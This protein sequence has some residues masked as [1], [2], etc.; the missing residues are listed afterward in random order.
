LEI[1]KSSTD[2]N[3]P[4][5]EGLFYLIT[6]WRSLEHVSHPNEA[7]QQFSTLLKEIGY[8]I[9]AV[10]NFNSFN[11]IFFKDNWFHLDAPRHL[12]IYTPSTLKKLLTVLKIRCL[13]DIG[14]FLSSRA[15]FYFLSRQEPT[16]STLS[17]E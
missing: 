13:K 1:I 7:S 15:H 10:P 4:F 16:F 8:C 2:E 9:I 17:S 11:A 3:L 5:S 12:C 6:G 14:F